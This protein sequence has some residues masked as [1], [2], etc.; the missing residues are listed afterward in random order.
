[1]GAGTGVSSVDGVFSLAVV[2]RCGVAAATVVGVAGAGVGAACVGVGS[3]T[4]CFTAEVAFGATWEVVV[5]C[6]IAVAAGVSTGVACGETRGVV[7]LRWV[8]ECVG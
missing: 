5:F 1:L 8:G 7:W 6:A 4:F 2:R 3:L